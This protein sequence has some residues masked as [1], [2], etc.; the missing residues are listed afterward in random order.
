MSPAPIAPGS[1]D[2]WFGAPLVQ[3]VEGWFAADEKNEAFQFETISSDQRKAIREYL[4]GS[5][6]LPSEWAQADPND[7][8]NG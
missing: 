2:G 5:E 6:G 1:D 3:A 4:R 8:K 7:S